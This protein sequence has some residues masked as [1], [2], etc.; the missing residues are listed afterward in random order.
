VS[1]G[2]IVAMVA[3]AGLMTWYRKLQSQAPKNL[4][5]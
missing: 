1:L 2:G 5:A 3:L 4:V